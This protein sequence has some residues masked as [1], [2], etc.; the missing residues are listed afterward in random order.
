MTSYA[1]EMRLSSSCSKCMM[2]LVNTVQRHIR[3]KLVYFKQHLL[4]KLMIFQVQF[5]KSISR[6]SLIFLVEILIKAV[7]LANVVGQIVNFGSLENKII[8]GKDNIRL[9]IELRDPNNV[10]MI[11]T[12]WGCY[13]KQVYDYSR[14]NM[15]TMIICVIR[16]CSVKEW[17]GAYSISSG[18]NSTHILLNPTLEFIEEFKASAVPE[19]YFA[20]FSD[21]LG[22]NLDHSCLVDVVGQ[23]VNFG[24]LENKIIKGKDNMRLL[25]EL[26]DPNNVK[27]MCTLWGC[28]AKQVYDYS[29]SNM[30]TM[31]ICDIRFCSVKEWKGAY[32]ISSG[33]NSTHILLN[34]TLEFS[35]EFKASLPDDSLALT[36][37]DSS[38]WSVVAN[39]T[40]KKVMPTTKVD[41]NDWPLFFCNTCDKEHSDVIS[42]FKLIAHVKDDSGETNFLLFDANAQ[43]IVCHSTA[44]LYDENE[45][46][47]FLPKAVS[48]LF[49]KRVLFEISVDADNI[50]RK[51]SQYV[52]RL[53][54]DDRE[55]VEE[56]ADLPPKPVLMLESADDISS[57]SGG[58]TATPLSKRKS[59]QDEDSCLE[60]QHSVNKKLSQ[61]K[62]K[63]E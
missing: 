5:P 37:S 61:K 20:D 50:K 57:G 6:T 15:S 36:K 27:M 1:R 55:M 18:Y 22:G 38:Q 42:R 8:K 25:I 31:I 39:T 23:I 54:T 44:E 3:T 28:Y 48:D 4:E 47:D 9:L 51:S 52:V 14:S 16:F 21:I 13:A 30:S 12:L 60:D 35:E 32:S 59:E 17:K 34:P 11:C 58:F 62:L 49:G 56:F 33:Y 19:N 7:W 46:E 10:K 43:Q 26:R 53:A 45:D 41:D 63:G 2:L 29:R 24:S 40:T